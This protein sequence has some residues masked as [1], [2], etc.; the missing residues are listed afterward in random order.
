VW[1]FFLR[2]FHALLL[3]S[4]PP[5]SR[6]TWAGQYHNNSQE[7][8]LELLSRQFNTSGGA[9]N[10]VLQSTASVNK[11]YDASGTSGFQVQHLPFRPDQLFHEYRFDWL[12]DRVQFF[13]DGKF[14][15]E[16]TENIPTDGKHTDRRRRTI[17]ES[18]E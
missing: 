1:S 9:I 12:P 10:L 2:T 11:G 15:Y 6:L 8:D 13:V 14:L 16:M 7:I 17:P 18:L 5:K 4:S 3:P